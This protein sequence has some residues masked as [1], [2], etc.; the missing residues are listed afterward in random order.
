MDYTE[1]ADV[2]LRAKI[3]HEAGHALISMLIGYR[4]DAIHIWAF[5][6]HGECVTEPLMFVTDKDFVANKLAGKIAERLVLTEEESEN[7]LTY[8]CD[9]ITARDRMAAAGICNWEDWQ[10]YVRQVESDLHTLFAL[11]AFRA[12]LVLIADIIERD[13]LYEDTI[14]ITE[15]MEFETRLKKQWRSIEE[16]LE[17]RY[18][19]ISALTDSVV[20]Q[21][22][23]EPRL[24]EWIKKG[25][26]SA[27]DNVEL[28]E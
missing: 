9:E 4:V 19:A 13:G 12:A 2:P 8:E 3:M 6:Q 5:V 11:P 21:M 20:C 22:D 25:Q 15:S 26:S 14:A 18:P 16:Q 10:Q 27:S 28:S 24:Q 23:Y 1:P 17:A 7:F